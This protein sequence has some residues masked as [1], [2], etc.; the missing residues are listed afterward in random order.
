[1]TT[2]LTVRTLR[3]GASWQSWLSLEALTAGCDL[4]DRS[5]M[6]LSLTPPLASPKAWFTTQSLHLWGGVCVVV[7]G[8]G[9]CQEPEPCQA[10]FWAKRECSESLQELLDGV[11]GKV[12]GQDLDTQLSPAFTHAY[13]D[14]PSGTSHAHTLLQVLQGPTRVLW[15]CTGTQPCALFPGPSCSLESRPGPAG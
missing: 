2:F 9:G 8:G 6:R 3:W 12:P 7:G 1:M 5:C 15:P 10:F 4:G 11:S 14:T 13:L